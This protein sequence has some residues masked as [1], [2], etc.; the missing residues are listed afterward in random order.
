MKFSENWLREW[1]NPSV[2]TDEL[3]TL[4][5]MAGLEVDSVGSVAEGLEGIVVSEVLS[6]DKLTDAGKLKIC[7]VKGNAEEAVQVVCGAPNVVAGM[8]TLFAAPGAKLPGDI[9]I[10]KTRLHGVESHGML[11]SARE[12]GLSQDHEGLMVLPADAETGQSLIDYLQLD[13]AVIDVDLTPNRGDC[14]GIEGVAREV[15]ALT[16]TEVS[17]VRIDKVKVAIPD[18]FDVTVDVPVSCPIYL[19]RVIRGI[20]PAAQTPLWMQERL[21]R[22]GI[23]SIAP[24]VDVTNYV[25]L[26]LGQPMH[27]FDLKRLSGGIV[28]RQASENEQLALLD[29]RTVSLDPA[30]LVIADHEK[31]LAIAGVMGGAD[32]GMDN[33]TD[34]LFLECAFFTPEAMAGKA[35]H[36]GLHTDSSH[37]FERG[38]DPQLQHRAIE[39]ATQLLLDIVGGRPGPVTEAVS[40]EHLPVRPAINL[41]KNRIQRV[42]G[43]LPEAAVIED[44]LTRLGMAIEKNDEGWQVQPPSFRFDLAIEAD[45]IE[46]IGRVYGYDKLPSI[47]LNGALEMRPNSETEVSVTHVSNV[48]VTRGYQEVITYSFVDQAL[49]SL[50]E[51][52]RTPVVLANPISSDMTDMRTSLW[53][54]LIKTAQYN[55][56]RQKTRM[57]FFEHGLRFYKEGEA[58]CQ[59]VVIAGLVTG[60]RLPEHW[61]GANEPIDFFDVKQDVF[62]VLALSGL[63]VKCEFRKRA[64]PALH[65]GKSARIFIDDAAVGWLGQIHPMLVNK[66]GLAPET[67]LFELEESSVSTGELVKYRP[68]SR[69]PSIRR[70][71]AVL[72]DEGLKVTDLVKEVEAVAGDILEKVVIFDVYQGQG[73]ETGRK[74]I[75]FGLILQESSRTLTD[76]EV[77]D[78]IEKITGRLGEKIGAT[79]RE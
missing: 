23:R 51:P 21:R 17:P 34:S 11:C 55:L 78:V 44:I 20:N 40:S 29:E 32:S 7:S 4:L 59:D 46:E 69:F 47:S 2:S 58:I 35:R 18:T 68:I 60:T 9:K 61:D 79:L 53:P 75:A 6:V 30:T 65:P 63:D 76:E 71:L 27:A 33:Q 54:G 31:V 36:Y 49:Q 5:T 50:L 25:L 24:V 66:T 52:G 22:G 62:A 26:E 64:H 3:V 56:H 1:V 15:G 41:R 42:L 70:D 48:L 57:R 39:R 37:R 67:T 14:L 13:D 74:S 28:V 12:L 45:L 38:V 19:G 10:R 8:K 16:G 73:I 43:M 72:V 77:A